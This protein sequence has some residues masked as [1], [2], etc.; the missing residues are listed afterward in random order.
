MKMK[1]FYYCVFAGGLLAGSIY[2][3]NRAPFE[4]PDVISTARLIPLNSLEYSVPSADPDEELSGGGTSIR[5]DGFRAFG[6]PSANM[7][8]FEDKWPYFRQ[9]KIVFDRDWTSIANS[10][11]GP[12]FSSSS[13]DGCHHKDGRGRP[14]MEGEMPESMVV[15][16][17][18]IRED[19]AQLPHPEYGYQLDY[20][21]VAGDESA[22]GHFEV[23]YDELRGRFAD[24]DIFTLLKPRYEF[25]DLAYGSFG[26][27]TKISVRVAPP[28]FGLGLLE[29]IPARSILALADPNDRDNDGISGRPNYSYDFATQRNE[30][31]R[32]G[33][34]AN[35]PSIAQQIA[36][37]FRDDM[38]ITTSYYPDTSAALIRPVSRTTREIELDGNDFDRILFYT[39]LLGV[40][41]RRGWDH[42]RVLQGKAI[43]NAAGCAACHVPHFTTGEVPSFPEL[44]N[45]TIRPYTDL[46]LHDMGEG[47]ADGRPDGLASGREWRT[48]P[49]WGIGLVHAVNR[50]TRFLHDG[51]ARNLEEAVLWHGGEALKSQSIYRS[52]TKEDR[53]ALLKFLE[54]L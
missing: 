17:T 26:A 33:W 2:L 5:D 28:V 54:S 11:L 23:A 29:S 38:G 20:H 15:Q 39:R 7:K 22:E 10:P 45:Q 42:I 1:I 13:C 40:P 16:L 8:P 43:F 19:G 36:R 44:S 46:L 21:T 48:P 35:Q 18:R 6:R 41:R 49:L 51:R 32:F 3:G 24:G 25:R 50:H 52:L 9:G 14:P 53:D 12:S 34:K 30:L 47:L 37:A 4:P 31:G 27:D